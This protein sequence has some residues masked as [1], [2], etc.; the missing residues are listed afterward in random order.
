MN[1]KLLPEN[2][3]YKRELISILDMLDSDTREDETTADMSRELFISDNNTVTDRKALKIFYENVTD[4]C[5][6]AVQDNKVLGFSCV[7]VN[8]NFFKDGAKEYFPHIAVTY[9]GVKPEHQQRGVWTKIRTYV[10][11]N[12]HEIYDSAEYIVSAVSETNVPSQNSNEK[13]GMDIVEE[14][15]YGD[16]LTYVYAKSI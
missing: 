12:Y 7:K 11:E 8:D 6:V 5:V 16:E 14:L 1:L 4:N 3:I 15:D 10:E 13:L 9:S 2:N